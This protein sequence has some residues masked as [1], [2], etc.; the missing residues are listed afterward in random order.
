MATQGQPITCKAA[1]AWEANTPLVIEDVQVAP[2]QAGEVRIRILFT[3]L[4]HTDAYTWSGKDP[5][6]LFPC[7]LGHEAAGIVE[8][9][10]EGVTEVQPGDHVIPC[11]QAECREC[12]FCKSGKTNLCGKVRAANDR[13]TRFSIKGKP[14]YHFMGTST[15]SQYTVSASTQLCMMLALLRSTQQPLWRKFASL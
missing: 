8:S 6:G 15:F 12:K 3:A 2:P 9:V 1:V 7:I 4:C 14:I 11:Y 5:E 10:G 13:K